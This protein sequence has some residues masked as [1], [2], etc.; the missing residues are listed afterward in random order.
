VVRARATS[1][2]SEK[3]R[4]FCNE[5]RERLDVAK[6][7]TVLAVLRDIAD[8]YADTKITMKLYNEF[9]ENGAI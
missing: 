8:G 2:E 5:E 7:Q 6:Q 9:V 1:K 3:I 4:K